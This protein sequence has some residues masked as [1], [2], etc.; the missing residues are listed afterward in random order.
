[1]AAG[2]LCLVQLPDTPPEASIAYLA[3]PTGP[4]V[5]GSIALVIVVA[6]CANLWN[7]LDVAPGRAGKW[8]AVAGIVLLLA[9]RPLTA[10]VILLAGG[11]GAAVGVLPFDLRER[12]ML[13]DAGSNLLGV[14][15]GFTLAEAVHGTWLLVVAAVVVALNLVAETVTLSRVISVVPPLRWFDRLGRLPG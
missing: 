6:G 5:L 14:L 9:H 7:G 1:V 11:L 2:V 15:V 8:F 12:G 3:A 4:S 13:G 10:A